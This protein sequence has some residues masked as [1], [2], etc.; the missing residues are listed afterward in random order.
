MIKTVLILPGTAL[1]YVPLLIH[2]FTGGWPFGGSV[3][4][5]TAWSIAFVL[6]VPAIALA[7]TTMRLFVLQGKGTPAP[8]DPPTKFVVSGPYSY[9][10]NPMLTSV[11]IMI[12]AESIAFSSFALLGWAV[13]FFAL[14][15][16]YFI[17]SEEPALERRFG[18]VYRHYKSA[19]PRW[20]PNLRPYNA[21]D[22]A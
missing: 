8:W 16:V 22:G 6:A 11:M 1:V 19:V 7:A 17:Y 15:T 10:R 9:V 12:A 4:G 3:G 20:V 21:P 5:V 2:Y 13:V 14:N 18:S